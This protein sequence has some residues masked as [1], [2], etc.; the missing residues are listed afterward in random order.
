LKRLT[1]CL[2]IFFLLFTSVPAIHPQEVSKDKD[3]FKLIDEARKNLADEKV[4][5]IRAQVGVRRVKIG[6]RKYKTVPIID[7]IGREMAVAIADA[8]DKIHIVRCIKR[9]RGLETVTPGVVLNLRRDN[10]FN[11]DIAVVTPANGMVLAVKYPLLNEHNRF[12]TGEAMRPILYTPFS[13]EINTAKTVKEGNKVLDEFVDKAYDKLKEKDVLSHA[14]PGEKIT[15]VI[16]KDVLKTLMLNEHIDPSEF[17]SAG[18]ASSLAERVLVIIGTNKETAYA[19]T[20]SPAG[21]FGLVQMIPSTYRLML[22][23]Y[24][25]AQLNPNFGLGMADPINAVMAQVLLCDSDWQAINEV[26]P[27]PAEKVGPYLA[28]AYNGGVGHVLTLLRRNNTDWM[29]D[30]DRNEKPTVTTVER[31]PVRVRVKG[32]K[33]R[34]T[35]VTKYYNY[36]VFRSETS[37]YVQQYHWLRSFIEA[38]DKKAAESAGN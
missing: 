37:K 38:R 30:P 1:Y 26:H 28:A 23:K 5:V 14:F 12:G 35:Y 25:T 31:V 17:K 32:R 7:V 8:E 18:L 15:K 36:P 20:I 33:Y 24:P 4:D 34:T 22:S 10:G 2:A 16:P 6:R 13:G 29:D 19:Y 27:L 9:E 11:S 21:A 3:L